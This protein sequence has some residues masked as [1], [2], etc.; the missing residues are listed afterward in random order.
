M[1]R[2]ST[3]AMGNVAYILH[4]KPP[5]RE[6]NSGEHPM[7]MFPNGIQISCFENCGGVAHKSNRMGLVRI[8]G[9]KIRFQPSIK[10]IFR[11]RDG[12]QMVNRIM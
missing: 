2:E 8:L 10:F 7:E 11:R 5:D 3:W 12:V 1:Y 9:K 6:L 4:D